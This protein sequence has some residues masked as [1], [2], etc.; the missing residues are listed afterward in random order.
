MQMSAECA[1]HK[2]RA[3]PGDIRI[4]YRTALS[5]LQLK[6]IMSSIHVDDRVSLNMM[7]QKDCFAISW[8]NLVVCYYNLSLE[9]D[10]L[11]YQLSQPKRQVVSPCFIALNY[12]TAKLPTSKSETR[13]KPICGT[14]SSDRSMMLN[15]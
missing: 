13:T 11:R 9:P 2:L 5:N 15:K 6:Y 10:L 3:V 1:V 7:W 8:S 12:L 14:G 4:E